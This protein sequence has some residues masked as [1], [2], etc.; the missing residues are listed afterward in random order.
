MAPGHA[1][2]VLR[3]RSEAADGTSCQL[4]IAS[5]GM[6]ILDTC[7]G[8]RY[9]PFCKIVNPCLSNRTKNEFEHQETGGL[10]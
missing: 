3:K 7:A 2:A 8:A 5:V 9:L 1:L 6:S 4:S 10:P